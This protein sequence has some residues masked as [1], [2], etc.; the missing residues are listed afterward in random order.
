[1]RSA[2]F[3][4]KLRF[5]IGLHDFKSIASNPAFLR[6]GFTTACFISSGKIPLSNVP[7]IM[8]DRTGAKRSLHSLT[9]Q[10]G[11]GS[12]SQCLLGARLMNPITSSA[13]HD[14]KLAN[15]WTSLVTGG[16][17]CVVVARIL[18]TL[19]SK[20]SANASALCGQTLTS[21][22]FRR[23]FSR[24]H[25]DFESALGSIM[26]FHYSVQTLWKT[27]RWALKCSCQFL[28]SSAD[29]VRR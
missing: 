25:K 2:N 5:D 9:I 21:F 18:F 3:D 8:V 4:V 12:S 22:G 15:G 27:V 10:V 14:A 16:P 28:R 20:K 6:I 26:V 23:E 13:K 17:E 11:A 29:L 1:M 7:F 24:R 19:S